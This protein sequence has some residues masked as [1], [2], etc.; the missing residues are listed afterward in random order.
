MSYQDALDAAV[1]LERTKRPVD[2]ETFYRNANDGKV[3]HLGVRDGIE[4]EEP[5]TTEDV[6]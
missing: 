6:A 4:F 5:L 1:P 3:W 2:F